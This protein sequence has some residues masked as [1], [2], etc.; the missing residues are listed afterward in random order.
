MLSDLISFKQQTNV[1]ARRAEQDVP[2]DRTGRLLQPAHTSP[3]TDGGAAFIAIPCPS[4]QPAAVR[5][6]RAHVPEPD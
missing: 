1:P 3:P 4:E 6:R 2:T 5:T